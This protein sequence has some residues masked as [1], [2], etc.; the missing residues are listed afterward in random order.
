M[1]PKPEQIPVAA[2]DEAHGRKRRYNLGTQEW[3]GQA[4][5]SGRVSLCLLRWGLPR[6]LLGRS[7]G[8]HR[9]LALRWVLP[10]VSVASP[11][12]ELRP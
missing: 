5:G 4:L 7:G 8:A 12:S 3:R 2:R 11:Q 1:H 6:S 10:G 9:N